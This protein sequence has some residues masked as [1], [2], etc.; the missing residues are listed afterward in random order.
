MLSICRLMRPEPHR[1]SH[2]CSRCQSSIGQ[3]PI[4][5][6]PPSRN[7]SVISCFAAAWFPAL[8]CVVGVVGDGESRAR[9]SS[10]FTKVDNTFSEA[11]WP[12]VPDDIVEDDSL[13]DRRIPSQCG[14]DI[15]SCCTRPSCLPPAPPAAPL[16][17]SVQAS[18]PARQA[19]VPAWGSRDKSKVCHV[20]YKS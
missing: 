3:R 12:S 10:D 18:K 17:I 1:F 4:Y 15:V 14:V 16:P 8:G 2:L 9:S 6:A 7:R 5:R 13:C 11:T 20:E 19:R